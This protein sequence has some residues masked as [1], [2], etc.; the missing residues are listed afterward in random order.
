[1]VKTL[2]G[3]IPDINTKIDNLT[4]SP[5]KYQGFWDADTN[6]PDITT[7]TFNAGDFFFVSVAGTQNT[8]DYNVHDEVIFNGTTWERKPYINS[9]FQSWQ[10]KNSVYDSGINS[11]SLDLKA[12]TLP[13]VISDQKNF[14]GG[15]ELELNNS[16]SNFLFQEGD[17][18]EIKVN[19]FLE[20]NVT[21][22]AVVIDLREGT[23][24]LS[25]A[26]VDTNKQLDT[27]HTMVFRDII[28]TSSMAT[29]GL[30]VAVTDIASGGSY[31]DMYDIYFSITKKGNSL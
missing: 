4:Q 21:G 5:L 10:Y 29:N 18:I 27:E 20:L 14:L 17:I 2:W 22:N 11:P 23:T 28:I 1:M 30:N 13:F 3:T 15:T 7:G 9:D 6:T 19:F 25:N 12:V 8:V 31:L 26:M 24:T 16:S